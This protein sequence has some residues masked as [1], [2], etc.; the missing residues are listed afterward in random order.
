VHAALQD[1][2]GVDYV[3]ETLLFPYDVSTGQR[4]ERPVDRIDVPPT[5]LVF[6]FGHDVI[7]EAAP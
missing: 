5:A 7:A 2:V 6:S 1:V 3:D 4:D